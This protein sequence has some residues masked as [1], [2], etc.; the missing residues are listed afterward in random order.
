MKESAEAAKRIS[1]EERIKNIDPR[2]FISKPHLPCPK[3]GKDG[4]GVLGISG[5]GYTRR[6]RECWHDQRYKLPPVKKKIIYLDQFVISKMMIALNPKHPSHE[7]IL[8]D[9]PYWLELFK[10]LDRLLKLQLIICPDS[11]Y[12]QDESIVT[13]N[14]KALK[15]IYEHFSDGT[16]FYDYET[17]VRFQVHKH[18]ESYLAGKPVE[19]ALM[20]ENVVIGDLHQWMD[21]IRVSVGFTP[22]NGQ[23]EEIRQS[24]DTL[25]GHL[26]GVFER[27]RGETK[28]F[29][30]LALEEATAYGRACI[31]S[32]VR[33]W[34]K[35]RLVMEGKLP[36]DLE[37]IL[38]PMASSLITDM[39]RE[40]KAA[41]F[42]DDEALRKM[43][44]YFSSEH[45][46]EV[47][48]IRIS[49]MLFA[50][51]AR[52]AKAGQLR[53]P[54]RGTFTDVNAIASILP[55]CDAIF[56]DNEYGAYLGESPLRERLAYPAKV[57]STNTRDGFLTYLD[58]IE[59][60]ADPEH[61]KTV[62]ELYG[63]DWGEPYLGILRKEDREP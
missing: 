9:D 46:L 62:K 17:I 52:K 27:W 59:K 51:I 57:F 47:P 11:F 36:P 54:S 23:A 7:R 29:D 34:A 22:R 40:I 4:F 50:S 5:G 63:A 58:D 3:C 43:D 13:P 12:H 10:K 26:K 20:A 18:L 44:E 37:N 41:G 42:K 2:I 49:S 16:T 24:R 30:E 38:P 33:H 28:S 60:N 14:F 32:C 39:L 6:C 53:P 61:M 55:Y 31:E 45:I 1:R 35:Q 21:R 19:P 15:R 48:Y 56:I 25:Y 8:K